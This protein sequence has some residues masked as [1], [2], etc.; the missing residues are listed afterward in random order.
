MKMIINFR[1]YHFKSF[2][3]LLIFV[4]FTAC[5]GHKVLLDI[6]PFNDSFPEISTGFYSVHQIVN[7]NISEEI[8]TEFLGEL[9]YLY[10][11]DI[12]IDGNYF[13]GIK[14]SFLPNNYIKTDLKKSQPIYYWQNAE[15]EDI[16]GDIEFSEI[17]QDRITAVFTTDKKN[18]EKIE[19]RFYSHQLWQDEV[20]TIAIAHRGL[21]YQPPSNYDGI[22]P[23]NS[24]PGFEA[25][26]RSGYQG[27]E[28]DV[29]VTKDKRF[30]IS[31][32]E[33][34]SVATTLHGE[35]KDKNLSEFNNALI[36]KSAAI[37]ENK[38]TAEE[39]YIAAP[40]RSLYDILYHFI[41]DP[42]LKT[43]VVDIK[44][45]TDE[46]IIAAARHDFTDL[47]EEQQKK[48]LFL[49]REE[50]TAK[51]L[52]ELCP[53]SD[54]A[55]EGSIGIEPVD[56]LEKFFP[57][58]VNVPRGSHNTVSFGSNWI[59]A[60]K[61][62]ETSAEMIGT[63]MDNAE[64]YNYKVCMWTFSKEWRFNFLREHEFYPDFILSDVPYY[65]YA[66]QQLRYTKEKDK[67]IS[68]SV[69]ITEK[70]SNPIYKRVYKQYV[71]DFWFQS[72]TML[73]LTYGI[74]KPNQYYFEN[75]FAPVGNWEFKLGRSVLNKFSKTNMSLDEWYLFFSYMNSNAAV[76]ET[77][78]T[79]VTTKSYRFGFGRTEGLGY[80]GSKIAFVPYVSQSLLWTNLDDFSDAIKPVDGET[81]S[82][83]Y[84]ILNRYWGTFRFGD[85]SLYGLK[86]DILSWVEII[87][88][89]E[90][91]LVYPRHLFLTW[92]GSYVV[93]EIGYTLLTSVTGKWVDESPLFG[94]IVN[95]V[96]RAGYLYT[97][98]LLREK[99]MNWPF[100][101]E[102]PLRYEIFN[103]GV[104]LVL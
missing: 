71:R 56:E 92:A 65:Q 10:K 41:D 84:E 78:P 47:T 82:N 104:S 49:T 7:N 8:G 67:I 93:M 95:F 100:S 75:D 72:R 37:P 3:V 76:G 89:Y 1:S 90:T 58:A 23:A 28:L 54:V 59:L 18:K 4:F 44:P 15:D 97:Y 73:E 2:P 29:R 14:G 64:K 63:V 53:H 55:L 32:D 85:R 60:F 70:Y 61:S 88:N 25:A 79:G 66:L 35:V 17:T 20:G 30:I 38:T 48:I 80:T 83:D 27:F 52:K 94:P 22:F 34:L 36:V 96:V 103:L 43:F 74:G 42:R 19:F 39:S 81:P 31:H 46:N 5:S 13:S 91:A 9:V 68:D 62:I 87:A 86:L 51:I 33:D 26:L 21:C 102:A 98:Y 11:D 24:G 45:D 99:N 16:K 50:S 12:F 101:T 40:M 77:E 6:P 57:E 69:H